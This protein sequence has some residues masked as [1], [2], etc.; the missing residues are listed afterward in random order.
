MCIT[1]ASLIKTTLPL[2]HTRRIKDL[3]Q[4]QFSVE[5][6]SGINDPTEEEGDHNRWRAS[7]CSRKRTSV[8]I[9]LNPGVKVLFGDQY[10]EEATQST[11]HQIPILNDPSLFH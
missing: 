1:L 8:A 5:M 4:N 3:Q 11:G 6:F 2:G 9:A 10:L 7:A